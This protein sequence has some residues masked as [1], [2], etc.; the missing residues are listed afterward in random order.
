LIFGDHCY[1]NIRKIFDI[2]KEKKF[3]PYIEWNILLSP[4][5]CSKNAMYWKDEGEEQEKLKQDIMDE[6]ENFSKSP[7]FIIASS[8]SDFSNED[9]K[10]P[11]HLKARNRYEEIVEVGHFLC[12]HE[13]LDTKE[14]HPIKFELT[15]NGLEYVAINGKRASKK[16]SVADSITIARGTETPPKEQVGFGKNL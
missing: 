10:N 1:P 9:G 4:H 12:T 6:F 7:A 14:P 8:E 2:T 5:H 11:P 15:Q 3:D 13:H 16:L